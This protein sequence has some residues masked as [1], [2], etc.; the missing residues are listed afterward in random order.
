MLA[1]VDDRSLEPGLFVQRVDPAGRPVGSARRIAVDGTPHRPR[2]QSGGDEVVLVYGDLDRDGQGS[3]EARVLGLDL[4]PLVEG[5]RSLGA[6][7]R[8]RSAGLTRHEGAYIAAFAAEGGLEIATIRV[9]PEAPPGEAGPRSDS[10]AHAGDGGPLPGDGAA[11]VTLSRRTVPVP[12]DMAPPGNLSLLSQGGRL[13]M[14]SDTPE[15]WSIQ[16]HEI[17]RDGVRRLAQVVDDRR[18]PDLAWCCPALGPIRDD[19]V[20]LLWQGPTPGLTSLHF[21]GFDAEGTAMGRVVLF[22]AFV[23]DEEGESRVGRAPAFDPALAPAP[24]GLLAAFADNRYANSEILLAPLTC[25][26]SDR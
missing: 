1:W 9:E 13:F 14:A 24:Y 7:G 5:A 25:T 16:L 15:G 19:S 23:R 4:A 26:E 21:L 18:H 11:R 20:A 3:L 12:E 22:E 6:T 2:V 10:G 17:G 8:G